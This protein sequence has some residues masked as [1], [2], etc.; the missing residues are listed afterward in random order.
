MEF[1]SI[2]TGKPFTGKIPGK[3]NV[4]ETEKVKDILRT[5][6]H[7]VTPS[8]AEWIDALTWWMYVRGYAPTNLIS[9]HS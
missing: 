7:L 6:A 8:D 5:I 3:V 9:N 4:L 1:A 2:S